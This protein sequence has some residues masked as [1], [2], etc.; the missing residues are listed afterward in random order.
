MV[1]GFTESREIVG[2]RVRVEIIITAFD[3]CSRGFM[4]FAYGNVV[5]YTEKMHFNFFKNLLVSTRVAKIRFH[6]LQ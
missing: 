1:C 2:S 3:L 5:H 6:F 4:L